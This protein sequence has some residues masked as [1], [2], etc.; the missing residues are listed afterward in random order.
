[1]EEVRARD[2]FLG[3]WIPDLF[4]VRV[5]KNLEWS[6]FCPAECPGLYD[7]VGDKFVEL[8]E[9]Y[10]REGRARKVIKAQDL[11]FAILEAQIETGNPYMMYKGKSCLKNRCQMVYLFIVLFA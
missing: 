9:K 6:L 11:W 1:V 10:E 7:S 2:L 5:E 3:L 8:Y 4:M